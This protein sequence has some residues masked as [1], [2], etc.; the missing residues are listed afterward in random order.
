MALISHNDAISLERIVRKVY[1]CDR[2][3]ISGYADA[4]HL[5]SSP[6]DAATLVI[7]PLYYTGI[8]SNDLEFDSFLA[9]YDNVFCYSEE[10]VTPEAIKKYISDLESIVEKYY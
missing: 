6:L 10:T 5:E 1:K 7:A 9:E 3:G 8:V 4:D 2:F